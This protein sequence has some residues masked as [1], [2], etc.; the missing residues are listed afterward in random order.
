M[1][2]KE[3]KMTVSD[4]G[5][6]QKKFTFEVDADQMKK[7]AAGV[8]A[9]LSGYVAIP[10]FRK[11]HAPAAIVLKRYEGDVKNEVLRKLV[12]VAFDQIA[13]DKSLDVLNCTLAEPPETF[14]LNAALVFGLKAILAPEIVLP[15]YKS[16]KIEAEAAAVTDEQVE[17]RLSY[18]RNMYGN[19][20]EVTGPAVAD[21]MLKVSYTSDFELPA[22]APAA[23]SRAVASD[24][25]YLWLNEP[26][27]IPGA[28]AALTGAEV[29]KEYTFDAAYPADWREA[30]LAG[31]TVKYTVKVHGIQRRAPLADAEL[32]AKM[33]AENIDA[34]KENIRTNSLR[35]A[36]M[37]R[38]SEIV[39]KVYNELDSKV[40]EFELP[41][42]LLASE[43]EKELREIA[44]RQVKTDDDAEKFKTE[45]ENHKTQA[46]AMARLNLR[47]ELILRKVANMENI[48]VEDSELD[49]QIAVMSRYYGY[50][51]DEFRKLLSRNGS[52]ENLRNNIL[53]NKTLDKIAEYAGK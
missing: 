40:S 20:A 9:E 30:A 8:A 26:E 35:E 53:M 46:E 42:D 38:H 2:L 44:A 34:L 36:E 17:E 1:A 14:E 29:G 48:T 6:N 47:K 13:A 7:T 51:E 27:Q 39:D 24:D 15:D 11:G 18:F 21:D 22:D 25:N 23:L 45:L 32:C 12:S 5:N 52:I 33:Q 4:A 50:K 16:F 3:L 43:T 10:G 28:T 19:Y 31:K 37:K 41:A 49:A